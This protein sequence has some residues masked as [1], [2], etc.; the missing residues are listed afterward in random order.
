MWV[1]LGPYSW[2]KTKLEK[3]PGGE[4]GTHALHLGLGVHNVPFHLVC[5]LLQLLNQI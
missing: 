5:I 4:A 1:S 3:A 2:V